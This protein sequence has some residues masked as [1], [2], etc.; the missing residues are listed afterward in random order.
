MTDFY[1]LVNEDQDGTWFSE[2][3]GFDVA[4][5]AED[6]ADDNADDLRPGYAFVLYECRQKKVLRESPG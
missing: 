4:A 5:D 2:P 6:Y 1:L 3:K